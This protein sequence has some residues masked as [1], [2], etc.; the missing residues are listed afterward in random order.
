MLWIKEDGGGCP[1]PGN[2]STIGS[3]PWEGS[4]WKVY[5][6]S[7][8]LAIAILPYIT[9]ILYSLFHRGHAIF[10]NKSLSV[11]PRLPNQKN[12]LVQEG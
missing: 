2:P 3:G 7:S 5:I 12:L 4:A 6:G 11:F 8:D 10:F 1:D 9:C